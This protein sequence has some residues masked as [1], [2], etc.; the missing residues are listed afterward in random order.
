[1]LQPVERLID[2]DD[3]RE[4]PLGQSAAGRRSAIDSG[5]IA[6]DQEQDSESGRLLR[7]SRNAR[8]TLLS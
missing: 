1:M 8:F 7:S 2:D 5:P 6:L 4:R 3:A